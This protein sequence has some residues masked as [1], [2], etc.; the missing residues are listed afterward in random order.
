MRAHKFHVFTSLNES[1]KCPDPL[2]PDKMH[3]ASI[4]YGMAWVSGSKMGVGPFQ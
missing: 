3:F 2:A 4:R 1:E